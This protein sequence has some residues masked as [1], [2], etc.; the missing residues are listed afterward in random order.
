MI[1]RGTT[2]KK[3]FILDGVA[4]C[5]DVFD[6]IVNENESITVGEKKS[7]IRKPLRPDQTQVCFKFFTSTDTN[8]K[9]VTDSSV[10]PQIGNL[11]VESPDTSLGRDRKIELNVFFGG[12]E[13]KATAID[14][15]S[16]QTA[17]VYLD[18]LC[19]S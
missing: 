16:K 7:F 8:V 6:I 4:K 9:Y 1:L 18:F 3:K 15:A 2:Q 17:V 12:T 10:G 13:I 19:K 5:K 11:V 14:R